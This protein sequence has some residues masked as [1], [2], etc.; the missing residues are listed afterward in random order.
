[1]ANYTD[2]IS[3]LPDDGLKDPVSV[4]VFLVDTEQNYPILHDQCRSRQ[5]ALLSVR[6]LK[7]SMHRILTDEERKTQRI[8]AVTLFADKSFR[9]LHSRSCESSSSPIANQHSITDR[10]FRMIRDWFKEN[11]QNN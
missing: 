5:H 2:K 11:M 1:M 3:I 9:H 8:D 10:Q 6:E 4:M 7:R